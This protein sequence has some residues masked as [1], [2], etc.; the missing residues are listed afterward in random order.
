MKEHS[1]SSSFSGMKFKKLKGF[2]APHPLPV[3]KNPLEL[4]IFTNSA[5]KVCPNRAMNII[6]TCIFEVHL[7]TP[8]R[9]DSTFSMFEY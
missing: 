2:D 7:I 3:M 5:G 8:R 9:V 1:K 6:R 4:G